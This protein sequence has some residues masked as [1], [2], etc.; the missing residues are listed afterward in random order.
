MELLRR[1]RQVS[2]PPD[3]VLTVMGGRIVEVRS[4]NTREPKPAARISAQQQLVDRVRAILRRQMATFS[5]WQAPA[6]LSLLEGGG[7]TDAEDQV[8]SLSQGFVVDGLSLEIWQRIAEL[9]SDARAANEPVS[10]ASVSDLVTFLKQTPFTKRPAIFLLDN[11]NFRA[12]WKNPD[13]EQA[14][15]Q[16]RGDGV[17]HCVFFYKRNSGRLPLSRETLVDL[18]PNLREKYSS[19][20]RL[21]DGR[22][23]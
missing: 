21:L 5:N 15:F 20:Q 16:F 10:P 1:L 23:A 4:L 11:G 9:A 13:N 6:E 22:A 19:F 14:A 2:N 17:V 18:M 3:I 7:E 12:V 8:R